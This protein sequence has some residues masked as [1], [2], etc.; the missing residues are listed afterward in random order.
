MVKWL[1]LDLKPE[2]LCKRTLNYLPNLAKWLSCVLST[3]LYGAF[4]CMFLSC[5]VRVSESIIYDWVF[6]Y[7]LSGS[8]FKSSCS[9]LTFRF[10]ACFEQRVPWHSGNYRV[11]IHS[12][13]RTWH[14]K[15]I[16]F[17]QTFYKNCKTFLKGLHLKFNLSLCK[18][19][20]LQRNCNFILCAAAGK[21]HDQIIKARNIKINSLRQKIRNLRK[22]VA[23][24]ISKNSFNHLA[25]KSKELLIRKE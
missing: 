2:Q 13:T 16:Q 4:D 21:I 17:F 15:N 7:E 24:R 3:Y 19:R 12:E 9:H 23:K 11:W 18:D 20:N 8:G 22:T 25:V 10:R 5:H 14:D 1:Q 6:V